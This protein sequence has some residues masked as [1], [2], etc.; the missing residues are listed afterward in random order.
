MLYKQYWNSIMKKTLL[1]ATVLSALFMAGTASATLVESQNG[2]FTGQLAFNGTI[3]NTNPNWAWGFTDQ[4][5]QGGKD[6]QL[7]TIAGIASGLNTEWVLPA[8][9]NIE[10]FQGYMVAPSPT[11][12]AGLTPIITI[13]TTII[14]ADREQSYNTTFDIMNATT[15]AV[16]GKVD[17]TFMSSLS[18]VMCYGADSCF[19]PAKGNASPSFNV[20]T[21]NQQGYSTN[22]P[23]LKPSNQGDY[24]RINGLGDQSASKV[25]GAVAFTT[26][27]VKLVITTDSIPDTWSASLPI[28]I[29][30][31]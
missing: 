2:N 22:Y 7:N 12:G 16:V 24:E 1:A 9:E 14:S 5:T 4:A 21:T 10:F 19:G 6:I 17:Y 27:S 23:S 31:K 18:Q 3:T 11:G 20:L 28:T 26:E 29:S 15:N 13:G 8:L 30:M 25:S